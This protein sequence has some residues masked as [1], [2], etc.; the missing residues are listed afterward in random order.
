MTRLVCV[1]HWC[2]S[3]NKRL[4]LAVSSQTRK[5]ISSILVV[6]FFLFFYLSL[7]FPLELLPVDPARVRLPLDSP[8]SFRVRLPTCSL[9]LAL[10][11]VLTEKQENTQHGTR[12][13]NVTQGNGVVEVNSTTTQCVL[14]TGLQNYGVRCAK[15]AFQLHRRQPDCSIGDNGKAPSAVYW[16]AGLVT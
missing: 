15:C 1:L 12:L 16:P 11:T 2:V 5:A 13:N 14:F 9:E 7:L 6:F 4:C 3:T 8:E 10:L